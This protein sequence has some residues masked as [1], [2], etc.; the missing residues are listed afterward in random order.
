MSNS[1]E[2]LAQD[3]AAAWRSGGTVALPRAG[4]GPATR[5]EAY[6]IQDRMAELIGGRMEGRRARARGAAVRGP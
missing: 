5:A 3:L 1:F 2:Q 4:R 6:A